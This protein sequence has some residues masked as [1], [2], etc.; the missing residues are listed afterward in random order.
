MKNLLKILILTI[1][2]VSC[3]NEIVEKPENLISEKKM[4]DILF[5]IAIVTSN[6]SIGQKGAR[7][8]NILSAED[9]VYEKYKI[10]SVQLA[11]S[12]IYYS[13]DPD[14]QLRIF[15]KLEKR[16]ETLKTQLEEESDSIKLEKIETGK[17]KVDS[18]GAKVSDE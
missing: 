3:K 5:D 7:N 12:T 13:S 14:V 11:E 2:V 17:R 15:E 9:Y 6:K 1:L 16:L 4:V 18:V 10:D 8:K